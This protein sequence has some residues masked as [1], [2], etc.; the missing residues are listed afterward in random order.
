MDARPTLRCEEKSIRK[1]TG[2]VYGKSGKEGNREEKT[3]DRKETKKGGW[4]I[5][6]KLFE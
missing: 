4:R 2:K 3:R 5:Q 6:A 1:E